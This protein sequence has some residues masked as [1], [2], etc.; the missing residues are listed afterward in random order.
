MPVVHTASPG[1]GQNIS[2]AHTHQGLS[3]CG[4]HQLY[5]RTQ[6][7]SGKIP[8]LTTNTAACSSEHGLGIF[9][10]LSDSHVGSHSAI[11]GRC[12]GEAMASAFILAKSS[13]GPLKKLPD[14]LVRM[15]PPGP[16]VCGA[17][18]IGGGGKFHVRPRHRGKAERAVRPKHAS[19]LICQLRL[20]HKV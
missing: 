20:E 14:R 2:G 19:R 9:K 11:V 13:R 5:H 6:E 7:T 3:F 15:D 1:A 4:R 17:R 8:N 18:P 10:C 12:P 16:A